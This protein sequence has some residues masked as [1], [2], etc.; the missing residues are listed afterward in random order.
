[1]QY[2]FVLC[3]VVKFGC[4]RRLR[5]LATSSRNGKPSSG[6]TSHPVSALLLESL[7]GSANLESAAS[8][9]RDRSGVGKRCHPCLCSYRRE[10]YRNK[11]A[12]PV[13]SSGL[14]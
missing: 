12:S 10:N 2:N 8:R 4:S 11:T 13:R 7:G 3:P 9:G 5:R 6:Y 14:P 1:A